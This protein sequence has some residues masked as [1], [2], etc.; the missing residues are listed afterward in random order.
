[1]SENPIH[2]SRRMLL[3]L[4]AG[5]GALG[6][7]AHANPV[8]AQDGTRLPSLKV[9]IVGAGNIGST[10][11]GF[12]VKAGHEVMLSSRHPE[13]LK[14]LVQELGP[15]S[16]AGTPA[17]AI[18][19]GDVVLLAVPYHAYPQIGRD[20]AAALRGKVLLNAGNSVSSRDG[21]IYEEVASNGIG[22]TTAKYLPGAHVVRAFNAANFRVFQRNANRPAPR[23][24]IPLAGDDAAALAVVSRLVTDAGFDPLVVGPLADAIKFAMGSP[25]FGLEMP[26]LELRGRLGIAP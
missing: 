4:M 8:L 25:G 15:R 21:T 24:T 26:A 18:A 12:W 10:L 2:L 9:G 1:M 16:R 3:A 17:E 7:S 13:K 22:M 19:F 23:M 11:G 5:T 14:G 20:N 6:F